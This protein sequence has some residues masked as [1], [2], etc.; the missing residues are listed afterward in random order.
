[1]TTA[2]HGAAERER[3]LR[4]DEV[5]A[6]PSEQAGKRERHAELLP[7]RPSSTASMPF[8]HEVGPARD[9]GNADSGLG[10]ERAELAEQVAHVRLVA[11]PP[12]AEHVRVDGDELHA[13]SLQSASTASAARSHVKSRARASP[14]G[15]S[16]S[17]RSCASAIPAAIERGVERVDEDSGAAGD[18]L[19]RPAARG[20][21]RRT[22]RHR[23]EHR[24]PESLVERG[25]D[26]A[27]CAAVE[28]RELGVGD[29]SHPAGH[30]DSAPPARADDAELDPGE[31]S[32][33]DDAPEVLP[34]LE[35][36]DRKDVLAL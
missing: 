28:L 22:A 7:A 31:P 12:A 10:C 27:T 21:D 18:L 13:S 23:L 35:R 16:S 1:M 9:R 30:V 8:G 29:L 14:S 26:D 15:T 36:R 34:R 19:G 3:V 2:G 6:D 17:R 20:H 32:R 11:G 4:V 25:V 5:G 24:D 33:L